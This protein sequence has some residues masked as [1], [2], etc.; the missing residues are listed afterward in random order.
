MIISRGFMSE[1]HIAQNEQVK[2]QHTSA[3]TNK[4]LDALDSLLVKNGYIA[5]N[6]LQD[7]VQFHHE[8]QEGNT[9]KSMFTAF[10][11]LLEFCAFAIMH[12]IHTF[13]LIKLGKTL[14]I[15]KNFYLARKFKKHF[16]HS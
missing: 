6:I 9:L 5:R 13:E 3:I 2:E 16:K 4:A 15:Q 14:S 12:P 11:V 1:N 10:K 8:R 7:A